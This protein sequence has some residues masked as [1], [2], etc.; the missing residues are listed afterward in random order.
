MIETDDEHEN[1]VIERPLT[2]HRHLLFGSGICD[3]AFDQMKN[4]WSYL[5][6]LRLWNHGYNKSVLLKWFSSFP[7]E[8][9][10]MMKWAL[11]IVHHTLVARISHLENI[12][13]MCKHFSYRAEP[14]SS[15]EMSM[16]WH[17]ETSEAIMR[18]YYDPVTQARTSVSVNRRH[19]HL[20]QTHREEY[21]ARIANHDMSL[22]VPAMDFLCIVLD[23]MLLQT[24]VDKW[25][26][27]LRYSKIVNGERKVMLIFTS[28]IR[29]YN[30]IGQV[31]EVR[32]ALLIFD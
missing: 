3:P 15:E 27:Y 24:S 28:K 9:I 32:V 12:R 7:P 5:P 8:L 20:V 31:V 22:P 1:S 13:K 30:S 4:D 25:D 2:T 19:E 29:R 16:L 21:L 14:D 10:S 6:M 11:G 18:V 17:E 23:D 26:R